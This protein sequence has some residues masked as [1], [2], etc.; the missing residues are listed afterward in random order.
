MKLFHYYDK[1]YGPERYIEAQVWTNKGIKED[2]METI[3]LNKN[4]LGEGP[5]YVEELNQISWVD[6]VGKKLCIKDSSYKEIIFPEKVSAGIPIKGTKDFLVL[7]ET[8]IFLYKDGNISKYISLE[9]IMQEGQRC[10]D[11]KVDA[12]GR[13]WF[14]TI[15]DSDALEAKGA[16]YLLDDGKI[17][18]KQDDVK[19]ANG[20]A[21]S[22]DNKYFYF[23][24]SIRKEVYC[25]DYDLEGGNLSNRKVLFTVDGT[26]DGMSI[27]DEDH[28]FVA[29]WGGARIEVRDNKNGFLL[30]T[31]SLPTKLITS[32]AFIHNDIIVTSA[33][34]EEKDKNAGDVFLL[35]TKYKGRKEYF[36]KL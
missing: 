17:I 14:T 30:D 31:I 29:V 28:L 3:N 4:I 5:Y 6:I 25:Y 23:V 11:A 8:Q 27:D 13:L 19:L 1:R 12:K 9:A 7:G 18:L 24:D 2:S 10:N 20:M 36:Y 26:P 32:V 33:K 35:K 34:L 22:K 21:F 15:T 16:L